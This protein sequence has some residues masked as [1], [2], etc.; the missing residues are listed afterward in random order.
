MGGAALIWRTNRISSGS[1]EPSSQFDSRK[2]EF[3]RGRR[4]R[5]P[6][7]VS[8][9]FD[10]VTMVLFAGLAVLFLQRSTAQEPQDHM[11]QY[12]PPAIALAVANQVGNKMENLAVVAW[13]IIAA[14]VVYVVYVLKPFKQTP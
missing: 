2:D 9:I 7:D 11:W 4:R 10:L 8:T 13:M 3:R 6:T 5:E 1:A 14:A 12:A